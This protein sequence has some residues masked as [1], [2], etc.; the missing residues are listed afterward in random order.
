MPKDKF[1]DQKRKAE[2][3]WVGKELIERSES[4]FFGKVL[5][6]FEGGR[7][8]RLVV[9]ESKMPPTSN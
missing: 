7:I 6:T 4:E 3:L 9:E 5:V 1:E 8:R 2:L